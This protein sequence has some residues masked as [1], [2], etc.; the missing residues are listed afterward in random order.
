MGK[1]ERV[2]VN[3]REAGWAVHAIVDG[4]RVRFTNRAHKITGQPLAGY[5]PAMYQECMRELGAKQL[6][7]G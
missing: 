7:L 2:W 6:Q 3:A 5:H 4:R 1:I